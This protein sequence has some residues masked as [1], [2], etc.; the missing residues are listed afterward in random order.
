MQHE[1]NKH[2]EYRTL[3]IAQLGVKRY[4]TLEKRARSI[5][6]RAEAIKAAQLFLQSSPSAEIQYD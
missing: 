6:S 3:K 1:S 2:G 5:V 4:N